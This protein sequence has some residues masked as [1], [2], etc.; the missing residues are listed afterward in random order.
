[1]AG[2]WIPVTIELPR[3]IEVLQVA[4]LSGRSRHEVI[5]MLVEFWLWV[6]Q[7]SA[8]GHV[9]SVTSLMLCE[10]IVGA[11]EQ[12]WRAVKTVGWLVEDA[13]GLTIPRADSWITKGAKARIQAANRQETRRKVR[14]ADVTKKSRCKR[15]KSV[16]TEQNIIRSDTDTDT[17]GRNGIFKRVSAD[18]LADPTA[19]FQWLAWAREQDSALATA[20]DGLKD[21]KTT[22][23][24]LAIRAK[25]KGK[26]P[27]ALFANLVGG[28]KWTQATPGFKTQARNLLN[29]NGK[30]SC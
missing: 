10:V 5:G 22:I 3:R 8:N 26:N 15:D 24:A 30:P 13:S 2:D 20:L 4:R 7:E 19:I 28:S 17:D 12:F 21:Q 23:V 1:M 6:Q 14:H 25:Q 9:P 18:T 11:D 16:T 27:A 29:G